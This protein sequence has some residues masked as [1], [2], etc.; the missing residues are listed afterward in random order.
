MTHLGPRDIP[1]NAL[2]IVSNLWRSVRRKGLDYVVLPISGAYSELSSRRHP[3]PILLNR[4][5]LFPAEASLEDMQALLRMIG[6]DPRIR[7]I[8]LRFG[9]LRAGPATL[10]SLR[11]MLLAL[12]V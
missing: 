7:G 11:R 10:C 4:L 1:G 12:R 5:P 8:V 3:L 2:R 6:D 9:A